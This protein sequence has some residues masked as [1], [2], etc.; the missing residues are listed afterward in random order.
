M[1]W[2]LGRVPRP[3]GSAMMLDSGYAGWRGGGRRSFPER[4]HTDPMEYDTVAGGKG[5]I[6]VEEREK[7]FGN[8]RAH[9]LRPKEAGLP[10]DDRLLPR[11]SVRLKGLGGVEIRNTKNRQISLPTDFR[12]KVQSSQEEGVPSKSPRVRR[13][14]HARVIDGWRRD[15]RETQMGAR[16]VATGPER[17]LWVCL[18]ARCVQRP[19]PLPGIP[20]W[21]QRLLRSSKRRCLRSASETK[22]SIVRPSAFGTLGK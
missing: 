8:A 6:C 11:S 15:W 20:I 12:S 18:M 13:V 4:E 19:V 1:Q 14:R 22:A 2:R 5:K 10:S 21:T 17:M 9:Q 3:R 7:D 16:A